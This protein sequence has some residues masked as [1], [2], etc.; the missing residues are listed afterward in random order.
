[1]VIPFSCSERVV[2]VRDGRHRVDLEVLVR[3]ER[4]GVLDWSPVSERWLSIVE[5]VVTEFLHMVGVKV[6]D[7]LGDL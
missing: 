1:M 7:T 3:T 6:A 2:H 5:P 4:R